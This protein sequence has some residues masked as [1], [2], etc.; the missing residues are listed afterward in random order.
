M[1]AKKLVK[2]EAILAA[3]LSLLE[4][5]GSGALNA[6]AI[7]ARLG[8]STQPI[9]LSFSGMEELRAALLAACKEQLGAYLAAERQANFFTAMQIGYIRFAYEKPHLFQFIYMEN[10]LQ[11]DEA[12]VRFME[13]TIREI[14]RLGGYPEAVARRFYFGAWF[15]MHGIACRMMTHFDDL[16][17]ED[18][19]ALVD[20]QFHAMKQFY[21][22]LKE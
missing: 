2:R 22:G 3:A 1:P 21:G 17:W 4:E 8:C 15:F 10:P 20:D 11:T 5:E 9:Y 16:R 14:M 7:A 19:L 13:A 12:D 18:I 6:R